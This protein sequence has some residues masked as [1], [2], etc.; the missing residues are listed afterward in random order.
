MK[1]NEGWTRKVE[2][3]SSERLQDKGKAEQHFGTLINVRT[4]PP[5]RARNGGFIFQG[6]RE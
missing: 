4:A 1:R 5:K 2:A 6:V 3:D